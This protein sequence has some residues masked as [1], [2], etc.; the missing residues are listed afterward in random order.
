MTV[1]DVIKDLPE[2]LRPKAESIL[3]DVTVCVEQHCRSLDIGH[4]KGV[5]KCM[6]SWVGFLEAKAAKAAAA[7][8]A[9]EGDENAVTVQRDAAT[10]KAIEKLK[11]EFKKKTEKVVREYGKFE[12]T[13]SLQK[14][15]QAWRIYLTAKQGDLLQ[16]DAI[17]DTFDYYFGDYFETSIGAEAVQQV[18]ADFDL[19]QCAAE[20]REQI[21]T[22][23]GSKQTQ[24][25]KRLK[26]VNSFIQ[27]S[28][29]PTSMVLDVLDRKSVV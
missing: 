12:R 14:E 18:L 6:A 21:A 15:Q 7:A 20:L 17:F 5:L 22:S 4:T 9:E 2:E 19:E 16:N 29:P 8:E 10:M 26:V 1:K 13:S 27:S 3:N 11:N 28:T 25:I 23:K 24:S